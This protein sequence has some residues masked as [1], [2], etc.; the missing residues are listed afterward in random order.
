MSGIGE[1][2]ITL[3]WDSAG[4]YV[5]KT[6]EVTFNNCSDTLTDTI[7]VYPKPTIETIFGDTAICFDT[8]ETFLYYVGGFSGSTYYWNI[9]N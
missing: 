8:S 6:I 3:V 2:T 1:D 5:I 7:I 9:E 4:T